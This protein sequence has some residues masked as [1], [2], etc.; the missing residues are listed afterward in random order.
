MISFLAKEY[1]FCALS[2][3]RSCLL[4]LQDISIKIPSIPTIYC[5]LKRHGFYLHTLKRKHMLKKVN[6]AWHLAFAQ[7]Y[8]NSPDGFFNTILWSDET[9]VYGKPRFLQIKACLHKSLHPN[10]IPIH[11]L[12]HSGGFKVM[13]WGCFSSKG[14]RPLVAMP[15]GKINRMHY[16]DLLCTTAIPYMQFMDGEYNMDFIFMQDNCPIHK[17]KICMDFLDE[18]GFNVIG[19][20]PESPDLNP[21]E[22]VWAI[23]KLKRQ[24]IYGTAK[25]R[26]E[27][28][29]Q[30]NSIWA[31]FTEE[32][33]KRMVSSMKC[34]LQA[35]ITNNGGYTKY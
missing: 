30:C 7:Y 13:F 11:K 31:G 19:W 32:F 17:V 29:Q 14:F 15:D 16:L 24:Q 21:I 34:H 3:I 12:V 23:L 6:C 1:Q 10:F 20:P 9:A 28:I 4:E 33:A 22:N 18:Q 8:I 27:L 2:F 5:Y 26:E 35:V 25:N